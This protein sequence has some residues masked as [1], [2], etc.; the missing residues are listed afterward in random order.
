MK[1]YAHRGASHDFPENTMIAFENAVQQGADGFESDLRLTRD[2]VAVLWH[3]ADLKRCA[4]NNAVV[5]NS[6]FAELSKI[7]PQIVSLDEFLDFAIVE[8]KSLA[9]ETKHPVPSRTAIENEIVKK[10]Q[11]E[12]GRIK[13]SGIDITIMS[14]SWFALEH[15]KNLDSTIEL[16]YLLHNF[17]PALFKRF[18]SAQSIGPE[19]DQLRKRPEI[20]ER[21][22][23][24]GQKIT[25]WTVDEAED[26]RLCRR[27]KVDT[28]VTNRPAFAR[29]VLNAK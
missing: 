11:S 29:E 28:L 25:I 17:T 2:G 10:L 22:S 26:I 23:V 27:L 14:F 9:L 24:A 4:G 19:I 5:S 12:S 18:T 1:I 8:K 21:I 3:D 7:Y 20:A 16:T 13:K 15:V 6:S